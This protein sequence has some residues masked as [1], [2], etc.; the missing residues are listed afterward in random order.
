M[1]QQTLTNL[2]NARA[3]KGFSH[4]HRDLDAAVAAAIAGLPTCPKKTRGQ[5]A[6]TA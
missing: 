2:C 4:P 6:G 3:R 1:N 5:N